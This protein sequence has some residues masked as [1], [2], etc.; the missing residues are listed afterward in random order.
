MTVEPEQPDTAAAADQADAVPTL[1]DIALPGAEARRLGIQLA[2]A[3][4]DQDR[5]R[6]PQD[7][8]A[9]IRAAVEAALPK[10]TERT[11][12]AL[13]DALMKEVQ[14]ALQRSER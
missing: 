1:F 12:A 7:L 8:D 2:A 9:R 6:P 10:V 4:P 13:R 11:A 3:A 14:T 5:R